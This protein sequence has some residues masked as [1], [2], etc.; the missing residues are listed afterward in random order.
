MA[1]SMVEIACPKFMIDF[2]FELGKMEPQGEQFWATQPNYGANLTSQAHRHGE[3][4][5]VRL[6]LHYKVT[7]TRFCCCVC[8]SHAANMCVFC[9]EHMSNM[10][11]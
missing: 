7:S 4:G 6:L 9:C 8:F 1:A 11:R 5:T 2:Y 3:A 10:P